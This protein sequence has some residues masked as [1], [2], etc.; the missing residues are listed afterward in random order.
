M[1]HST[2]LRQCSLALDAEFELLLGHLL[3]TSDVSEAE[4][5]TC[6]ACKGLLWDYLEQR[7]QL[8]C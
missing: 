1:Q 8:C 4:L 7:P 3:M 2:A 6:P 5:E